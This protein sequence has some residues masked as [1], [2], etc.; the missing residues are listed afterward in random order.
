MVFEIG[1]E[2]DFYGVDCNCFKLNN[3]IFEAV[4]NESDGYRSCMEE[5]R[6]ND[7]T[8]DLIFFNTPLARIR[9][10]DC[11]VGQCDQTFNGYNLVDVND[12][13]IWLTFGTDNYDDYYP[14]FAFYYQNKQEWVLKKFEE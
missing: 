14:Y 12:G 10:E 7:D 3:C 4:E 13:F 11:L 1:V 5:V 6:M 8:K 9:V 2:A